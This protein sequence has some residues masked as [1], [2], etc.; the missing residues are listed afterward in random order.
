M[1]ATKQSRNSQDEGRAMGH[2]AAIVICIEAEIVRV[3]GRMR[4]VVD[5]A[6]MVD[7]TRQPQ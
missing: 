3:G 6:V 4:A 1:L 5:G 2:D 7:K